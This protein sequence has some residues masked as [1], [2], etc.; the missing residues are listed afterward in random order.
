MSESE[1]SDRKGPIGSSATGSPAPRSER[2][3]V[4]RGARPANNLRD[5]LAIF[6][7]HQR[8]IIVSF[9]VLSLLGCVL[10]LGYQELIYSPRF[11]A[12]S[13]ILVKL[14]W[15][16]FS[17]DPSLGKR[18]DPAVNQAEMVGAE[19]SILKSRDIKE[20][21]IKTLTPEA[22]F[23][24]LAN[25]TPAGLGKES[26][27]LLLLEKYLKV[28]AA[29][30]GVIDVS[31][32]GSDP[33]SAAAVVN[34]LVRNYIE[35]RGEIYK[36]PK[37]AQYLQSKVDYYRQR[38]LEA[39]N[40]MKAFSES[41]RIIAFDQQRRMVLE[42]RSNLHVSLNNTAN[43]IKETQQTIAE[44]EKELK[45]IPP[46][47][48]TAAASNR[49]GD[50]QGRLLGLKLQEQTL[51]AKFR[52][53]NPLIAAVRAQIATVEDYIKKSSAQN[54]AIAAADPVY[55]EIQ[56]QILANKARLSALNVRY[57]GTQSQ[58][59]DLNNELQFFEANAD[60]YAALA[61]AV[62]SGRRMY[63]DY[64]RKLEEAK[65]YNELGRDK[66]TSVSLIEAAAPPVG[67]VNK[68]NPLLLL[69]AA[70]IVVSFLASLGI[71]YMLEV[72]KQGMSTATEAE[73]RLELPVLVTIPIRD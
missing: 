64:R 61:A 35:K 36:D 30:G 45:A 62:T 48:L 58:L 17:P 68:P 65:V 23:P 27:A 53:N 55:Q 47:E 60:K 26:E 49:A 7:K 6:F 37:S 5:Y 3:L 40:D 59:G 29:K 56:K 15:E 42:R 28:K 32:E 57:T 69:F 10:A 4:V 12:R 2:M 41:T 39:Q 46:S 19:I 54:P 16:N 44:L 21:V 18:Q 13:S 72:N 20:K 73:K 51:S 43:A 34:Q 11:E 70:A 25:E 38:L 22:I 9:L 14:G 50:A 66:M 24:S 33:R 8:T 1:T 63:E 71:A 31:F 52:G 67:P